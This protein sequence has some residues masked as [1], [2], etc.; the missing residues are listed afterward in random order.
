MTQPKPLGTQDLADL[1]MRTQSSAHLGMNAC[2]QPQSLRSI[3]IPVP[4]LTMA[5][6]GQKTVYIGESAHTATKGAA[7]LIPAR[8]EFRIENQPE[9]KSGRFF[10]LSLRFDPDTVAQFRQ[11]Y[12]TSYTDW[13][14]RP[15]WRMP[16][17]GFLLDALAAWVDWTARYGTDTNHSRHRLLEILLLIARHGY[18]GNL[19]LEQTDRW[20]QR[21]ENLLMLDPAR[22]WRIGDVCARLGLSESTLRRH[23]RTEDVGFR[24]LLEKVRLEAGLMQV[25]ETDL[26]IAQVAMACGY[27]SQSRFAERFRLR[28]GMSP[29]ELRQTR[30][31]GGGDVVTM[32]RP[33]SATA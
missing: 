31:A 25:M 15:T 28:F 2:M 22:E 14:T 4:T 20:A 21:I 8:T 11:I 10:G 33:G 26:Q 5:L 19:L 32:V 7:I 17:Q 16:A 13:D 12:G 18:G 3:S 1:L 30:R 29:V 23:L 6:V 24:D 9:P 27:Q